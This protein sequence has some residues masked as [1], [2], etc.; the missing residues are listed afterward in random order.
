MEKTLSKTDDSNRDKNEDKRA[1][2][3]R[4]GKVI[5][6]SKIGVWDLYQERDRLLS[7]FPTS[8]KIDAYTE[9]SNDLPFLWKTI[10]D[11]FSVAWPTLM[12][13]LFL[14]LV[15]SVLPALTLWCVR[16]QFSF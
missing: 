6:Y 2:E 14:S 12:L 13:Y 9:M 7:Y 3:P 5:E 15:K 16:L 1:F 10:G 11:L 4:K 8:L